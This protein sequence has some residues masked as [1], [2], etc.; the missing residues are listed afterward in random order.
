MRRLPRASIA[1]TWRACAR[2]SSITASHAA[3]RS[4][5]SISTTS[6]AMIPGS[7]STLRRRW[8]SWRR[9]ASVRDVDLALLRETSWVRDVR[10]YHLFSDDAGSATMA[11]ALVAD[12]AAGRAPRFDG[13]RY[14]PQRF[15][16]K[17]GDVY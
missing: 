12:L 7:A 3:S 16:A 17:A 11:G 13:A 1:N 8:S 15:R 6:P 14:D 4:R 5:R 9:T 2:S 10:S